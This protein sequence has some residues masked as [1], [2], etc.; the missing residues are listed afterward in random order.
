VKSNDRV[1]DE[2]LKEIFSE[3]L[4]RSYASKTVYN[5]LKYMI[6]SG[7]LKKGKRVVREHIAQNF[8]VNKAM[9]DRAFAKLKKDGLVI[10]NGSGGSFV[11]GN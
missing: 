11:K 1:P 5:Q 2:V 6:L 3:K 8:N 4:K 10:V 9:I 7:K